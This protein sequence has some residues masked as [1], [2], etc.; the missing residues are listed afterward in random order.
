MAFAASSSLLAQPGRPAL[1]EITN[2][3]CLGRF[4]FADPLDV[5]LVQVAENGHNGTAQGDA[6]A[7]TQAAVNEIQD[8]HKI[9]VLRCAHKDLSSRTHFCRTFFLIRWVLTDRS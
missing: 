4:P 6:Q 2:Q 9:F 5:P 7:D 1:Q 3:A 8:R